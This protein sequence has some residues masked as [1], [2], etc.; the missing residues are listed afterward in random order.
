MFRC[1]F[2]SVCVFYIFIDGYTHHIRQQVDEGKFACPLVICQVYNLPTKAYG[3]S[4]TK[5]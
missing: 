3:N 5:L 1:C 4:N 2:L